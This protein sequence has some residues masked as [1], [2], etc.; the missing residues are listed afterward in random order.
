[1]MRWGVGSDGQWGVGFRQGT[2]VGS[3]GLE[4]AAGRESGDGS[5]ENGDFLVERI[6]GRWES[7][8]GGGE[9]RVFGGVTRK[10]YGWPGMYTGRPA[11]A[12]FEDYTV[13]LGGWQWQ[14]GGAG[15]DGWWH[16][17]GG[18]WRELED[19][20]EFNRFTPNAFFE[21]RT[22]VLSLQGDGGW[23]EGDWRLDYRWLLLRDEVVRSTSLMNGNFARRDYGKA[24]V[25]LHREVAIGGLLGS[26]Y[27]GWSV[28]SSSEDSTRGLPQLG[29]R[30]SGER[31]DAY[32]EG[33]GSSQV[34]GYTVLG[35]APS[36][37]FGG[38]ADAGRELARSVEAGVR[39][40]HGDVGGRLVVFRREDCGLI[41]WVFDSSSPNARRASAMDVDVNGIEAL[42]Y[43]HAGG[44]LWEL[45]YAL[46]DKSPDYLDGAGDASF[47][48]LN[49][50]RH[51]LAGSISRRGDSW[52][53]RLDL[54]Y[55]QQ[56]EN[57][58]R[59]GPDSALFVHAY[60]SWTPP[61]REALQLYVHGRNL[62]DEDFQSLPGTPGARREW[63]AGVQ[64]NW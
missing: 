16:R 14:R 6:S 38:N 42:G 28:D 49:Y 58:L 50:A 41:D 26:V 20:Y 34:P 18:F 51:R 44:W 17:L 40:S 25:L 36:G 1:M 3:G 55:R 31:W 19:D 57:L 43:V 47:Y 45:S 48:A 62:T 53:L 11:L 39:Y 52:A 4:L 9:L 22:R 5:V 8:L 35:S 27:G 56:Q 33:S 21:H 10:A 46:L 61:G 59:A 37:L 2:E 13:M 7:V 15:D 54:E 32:L 23:R 60:G 12:E 24:A 64:I 30:L 29:I 63:Q